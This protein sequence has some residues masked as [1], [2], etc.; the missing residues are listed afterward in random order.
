MQFVERFEAICC[1]IDES[2][3]SL[4]LFN[5]Y[6]EAND[7]AIMQASCNLPKECMKAY[8]INKVY[9]NLPVWTSLSNP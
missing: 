1:M 2:V 5:T 6:E 7:A 4:G 3:V 8:Q 9:I